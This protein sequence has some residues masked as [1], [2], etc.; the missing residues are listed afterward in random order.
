MSKAYMLKMR[1][2]CEVD[3]KGK[4]AGKGALIQ[5]ELAMTLGV[6]QDQ[7]LFQRVYGISAYCSNAMLSNNPHSGIYE[8]DTTR[9][10]DING[11]NPNCNQGGGRDRL[12]N[13]AKGK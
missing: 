7:Y 2:G 12:R 9:T 1:G 3:S 5:E 11:G 4:R 13:K 6:T 8:A 10:L